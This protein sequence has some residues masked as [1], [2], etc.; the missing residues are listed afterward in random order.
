MREYFINPALWS[1]SSRDGNN[2]NNARFLVFQ[3]TVFT[4]W[5]WLVL[6]NMDSQKVSELKAF[7][8]LCKD[9]PSLLHLPEMG[10]FKSWLKGS[11]LVCVVYG[12]AFSIDSNCYVFHYNNDKL[13]SAWCNNVGVYVSSHT[14]IHVPP[15]KQWSTQHP[16][17]LIFDIIFIIEWEQ[18]YQYQQRMTARHAR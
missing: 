17:W 9:N 7:V 12:S 8:Q 5:V 2:N 14:R 16:V 13:W 3:H 1:D 4:A 15:R 6:R 11:V 10:F 18:T